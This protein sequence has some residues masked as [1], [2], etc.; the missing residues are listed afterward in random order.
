MRIAKN[1]L[2]EAYLT[3]TGKINFDKLMDSYKSH[4]QLRGFRPYRQKDKKGRFKSIPEAAMIYSF[5]TFISIFLQEIEGRS[6]RE[7]YV[8]L[9]NTDLIINVKGHEYLIESK[10]YYSPSNFKKGKFNFRI[11]A[12]DPGITEGIYLVFVDNMVS[13]E[14]VKESL[15]TI[16]GIEIKTY[17]IRYDEE[18]E[19][20]LRE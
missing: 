8:S 9:G 18:K 3:D 19:F 2:S 1:M 16:D 5:E 12:S 4:I 11:I 14:F 13:L 15:E 20:G 6:Y 17:L 10:K 7:A